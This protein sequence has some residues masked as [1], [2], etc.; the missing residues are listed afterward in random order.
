MAQGLL[1]SWVGSSLE[2]KFTDGQKGKDLLMPQDL[3]IGV[4]LA[5]LVGLIWAMTISLLWTDPSGPG[6]PDAQASTDQPEQGEAGHK[7]TV[8]A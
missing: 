4:L 7:H 1:T 2:H 5:G 3:V 8:A 6:A